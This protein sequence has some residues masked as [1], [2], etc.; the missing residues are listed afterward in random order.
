MKRIILLIFLLPL[1]HAAAQLPEVQTRSFALVNDS[2]RV[3][4]ALPAAQ[5]VL[6]AVVVLH[7]RFGMQ[8]NVHSVLKVLARMGFR[9][10]AP[11]LRSVS[12]TAVSGMPDFTVDS[13]DVEV[14]TQVAV[15]VLN[16]PGCNGHVGLLA[17]DVGALVAMEAITRFPFFGSASLFY[18][19]TGVDG[20]ASLLNAK[21]VL[22]LHVAQFDPLCSLAAVNELRERFMDAGKRLHVLYYKEAHPLFFNP[23]HENWHKK[24]TQ[25]AWNHVLKMLRATL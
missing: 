5:A 17:F 13:T 22:Q 6:P 4:Y 2:V 7:D 3:A 15:D 9:A 23:Q 11:E 25:A 19:P 21:T 14:V 24:N 8:E 16:E 12:Q 1:M 18:P 20:L 10:Y